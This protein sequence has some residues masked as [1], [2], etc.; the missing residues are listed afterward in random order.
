MFCFCC[1]DDI[2][3]IH[4]AK[5]AIFFICC[6]SNVLVPFMLTIYCAQLGPEKILRKLIA[7]S[8][9]KLSAFIILLLY[10]M[11]WF[12]SLLFLGNEDMNCLIVS[13]WWIFGDLYIEQSLTY[14]AQSQLKRAADKHWSDGALEVLLLYNYFI[15]IFSLGACHVVC[16]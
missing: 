6:M 13:L 5:H 10:V 4:D 9:K 11:T 2:L 7:V 12:F 16:K 15:I 3:I 1:C 14:K 8:K